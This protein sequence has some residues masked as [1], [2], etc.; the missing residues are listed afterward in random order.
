MP[1][2]FTKGDPRINTKGRPKGKANKTTEE[3]RDLLKRFIDNN[4]D[5]LQDDFDKLDPK[6]RL[7]FI[8]RILK[9]VLPAPVQDITQF[10]EEDLD[11]LINRLQKRYTNN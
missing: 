11:I 4:L 8:D 6:D 9:H 7:A 5:K 1:K 3:L 10:S 2:P